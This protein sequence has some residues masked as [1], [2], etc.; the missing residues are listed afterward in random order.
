MESSFN[1]KR[2]N[3]RAFWP[4]FG[5][6]MAVAAGVLA[7]VAGPGV[8]SWLRSTLPSFPQGGNVQLYVTIIIFV[9]ILSLAALIVAAA[10][11]RKKGQV[12]EMAMTKERDDMLAMKRARKARQREINKKARK[13]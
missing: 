5:L 11:P 10:A 13:G 7:Y 12:T 3:N 1:K 9:I 8:T 2:K 6:V 4:V